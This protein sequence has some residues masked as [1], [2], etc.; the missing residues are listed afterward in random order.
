VAT[1]TQQLSHTATIA[2]KKTVAKVQQLLSG[3]GATAVTVEYAQ[4][5]AVAMKFT[6]VVDDEE[7]G[8]RLP[9]DWQAALSFMRHDLVN[10]GRWEPSRRLAQISPQNVTAAPIPLAVHRSSLLEACRA[11][12]GQFVTIPTPHCAPRL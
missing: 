1:H 12:P 4:G 7:L 10:V 3:H 8:Y 5:E 11:L 9:I 2:T 6:I